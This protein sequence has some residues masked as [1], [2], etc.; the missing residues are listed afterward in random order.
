MLDQ[1]QSLRLTLLRFPL[2]VGVVF[3]HAYS[4]TVAFTGGEVGL[5]QPNLV[6]DFVR[7]LI[8][9]GVARIAVPLFFLMSGYLFFT[10]FDGSKASYLKKLKSRTQSLLIPL[11]FWNILTL[12]FLATAQAIPAAAAFFSGKN[13]SIAS[14]SVFEYFNSVFGITHTPIAYQ[15]WFIRDL[16]ILVLIVPLITI[17]NAYVPRPFLVGALAYWLAGEWQ[18]F[19][20]AS[21][22]LFFFSVGAFLA[23]RKRSLFQFDRF[24]TLN[25]ALYSVLVI[26]AALQSISSQGRHLVWGFRGTVFE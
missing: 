12:L 7:N 16:F 3:I 11:V 18:I 6:A 19:A 2:I 22:A 20:P 13:P 23:S 8:S 4:T 15:F 25:L 17:L 14:F 9:Q 10:G 1:E 26:L 21:D 5:T 24:G